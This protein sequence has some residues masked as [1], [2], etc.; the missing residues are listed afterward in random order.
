MLILIG[1]IKYGGVTRRRGACDDHPSCCAR[2][3]AAHRDSLTGRAVRAC[4]AP[5]RQGRDSESM[6]PQVPHHSLRRAVGVCRAPRRKPGGL[7]G[8]R[9]VG[10]RSVART[11]PSAAVPVA[12]GSRGG[13]I[14][15]MAD[16]VTKE[17]PESG[18]FPKVRVSQSVVPSR[19]PAITSCDVFTGALHTSTGP[20]ARARTCA[21]ENRFGAPFVTRIRN[22]RS[23]PG[24]PP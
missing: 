12:D 22:Q 15:N 20:A 18:L 14:A 19:A 21:G 8:D 23:G 10:A 6:A 24:L 5:R 13:H 17:G 3:P 11:G 9:C 4:R 16:W 1:T 2:R 7:G